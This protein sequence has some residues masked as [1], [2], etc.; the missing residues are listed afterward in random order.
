MVLTVTKVIMVPRLGTINVRTKCHNICRG[1]SMWTTCTAI[2]RATPPAYLKIIHIHL[3]CRYTN[4]WHLANFQKLACFGLSVICMT[5]YNADHHDIIHDTLSHQN[6]SDHSVFPS[7]SKWMDNCS[8]CRGSY[9]TKKLSVTSCQ[10]LWEVT[11]V[12][13]LCILINQQ[14]EP[15]RWAVTNVLYTSNLSW[16]GFVDIAL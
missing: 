1:I 3:I 14:N 10:E 15:H 9:W 12:C 7:I 8:R 2:L 13:D 6:K 11:M 16:P 5:R 4:W